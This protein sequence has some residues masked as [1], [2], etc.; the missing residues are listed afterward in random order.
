ME[1]VAGGDLLTVQMREHAVQ[2]GVHDAVRVGEAVFVSE[3]RRGLTRGTP[4]RLAPLD[5]QDQLP[6]RDRAT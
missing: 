2:Q 6:L 4:A 3:E 1:G 5:L